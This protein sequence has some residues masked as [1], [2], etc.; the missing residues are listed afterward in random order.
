MP[1]SIKYLNDQDIVR[2]LYAAI[3][4]VK[5]RRGL[6]SALERTLRNYRSAESPSAV[7]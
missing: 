4:E 6:T 5:R 7:R 2:L 3:D 1:K